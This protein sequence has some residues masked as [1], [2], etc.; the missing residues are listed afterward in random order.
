MN[1]RKNFQKSDM[2]KKKNM[3]GALKHRT[4]YGILYLI[5]IA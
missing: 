4:F 3:D 2:H 1:N 5:I